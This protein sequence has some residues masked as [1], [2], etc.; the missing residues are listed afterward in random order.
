[1]TTPEDAP[2]RTRSRCLVVDDEPLMCRALKRLLADDHEVVC[3]TSAREA[4]QRLSAG[5]TFDVVL[6]DLSMPG[7]SGIDLYAEV[8][9]AAPAMIPK[10][11][12]LTG[13]AMSADAREFLA[14]AP[15]PRLLKPFD[16]AELRRVIDQIVTGR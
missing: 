13:G 4:L 8:R 14:N 16:A 12:F 1:M 7:M 9:T 6:C 10:F 5:E 3:L 2:S 11:A 15:N